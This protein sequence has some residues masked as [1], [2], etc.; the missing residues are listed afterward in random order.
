MKPLVAIIDWAKSPLSEAAAQR[1]LLERPLAI[2]LSCLGLQESVIAV[3]SHQ[4][5]NF[6]A[7]HAERRGN[8]Q[9]KGLDRLGVL[10]AEALGLHEDGCRFDL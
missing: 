7:C 8:G 3:R 5:Q 4:P 6:L 9:R 1:A 10:A 2:G